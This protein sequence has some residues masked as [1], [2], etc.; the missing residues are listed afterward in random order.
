MK[1]RKKTVRKLS[2]LVLC[3]ALIFS[4]TVNV[5]AAADPGK[6]IKSDWTNFRGNA[7]NNAVTNAKV[8][9][10]AS[11][12]MLYWA[13]KKGSG[14]GSAAPGVPILVDGY[15][16]FNAGKEL[17]KMDAISGKVASKG[18]LVA[19]SS[20]SICPPTY[21]NGRIYVAL[22]NGTIQAFNAKTLK[23]IWVYKDELGGQPNT[24]ITYYDGCVYAGFWGAETRDANFV[25]LT[26]TDPN[27]KKPT[28]AK[29]AK[30]TYTV[31]GGFYW[32]G[33]YASKNFVL[34]GTDD[35]ESGYD[36]QTSN[37]LCFNPKTGKL[38]DKE[39][40][41]NGDIRSNVAYDKAT[42][43]YYFAS[44]GGT[45]YSVKV[46]AA[47]KI[48]D[49]KS[50]ELGGMST[51]TP[52][53]YNGRAYVGVAGAGQ[54][55][56][57]SG[58]NITVIDLN[59]WEIAY[60]AM[61]MGYPQ[62]SGLVSTGYESADGSVYVYFFDN[63]T[64]GKLRIIK[65]KPGQ[66]KVERISTDYIEGEDESCADILFTP[67]GAQ[68][69]Y[70]ICSPIVDEYGTIYFKNDSA[71]IMALGSKIESIKVTKKPIQTTYDIGDKGNLSGIKVTANL[72]NGL[73]RDISDYVT[74]ST[75]AIIEGQ[76]DLTIYYP[77][78]MYNDEGDAEPI[79]TTVDIKVNSKAVSA[80]NN[81][82]KKFIK[83]SKVSS[84]K[85]AAGK[86]KVTVSWKKVSGA[87]G[88]QVSRATSKG[89]TYTTKKTTSS[90]KYV[91]TSL[92]S[93]KT[94][95]YKVRAYKTING[96]KYYGKWSAVKLAKVK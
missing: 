16:Y 49:L 92:T 44:K 75:E 76:N 95:Y 4:F 48:S 74:C 2:V 42:D 83:A 85:T 68:A 54:F 63:Y 77:Y 88:Y 5:S 33:C 93:K 26:T 81:A 11:K 36:S 69:Q 40:G 73:T 65:D 59:K 71:H 35:G 22:S 8:P 82:A 60:Q 96:V 90:T 50:V 21:A 45:F 79:F 47:G 78:S 13:T 25:C 56:K 70:A 9:K 89:G 38:L 32:A 67:K 64:P 29:K 18:N 55:T 51:S 57:Y 91:N 84:V 58:H 1:E 72:A 52:S 30:W 87:T 23:S 80:K 28:E 6:V 7:E 39:S 61:T 94:Y 17:V 86:K 14:W 53:V 19:A 20:F 24:T 66:K 41:L 3:V 34:V 31:K 43:R 15:L 62:T 37:L 10:E 27:S 46:S 12:A